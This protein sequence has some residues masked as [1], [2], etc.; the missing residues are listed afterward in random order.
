MYTGII[1]H[2]ATVQAIKPQSSENL[3]LTFR[4][5]SQVRKRL[6]TDDS[7]SIDGACLTVIALSVH[8]FSVEAVPET[9]R[10]TTLGSLRQGE[11][12]NLELSLRAGDAF[13]G[14]F[15]M[16]HVDGVGTVEKLRKEGGSL[17]V[18]IKTPPEMMPFIALKGAIAVNG[19]S[20]TVTEVANNSFGVVLIPH[21][22]SKTNLG[23]IEKGSKVNIEVDLIARMVITFLKQKRGER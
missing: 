12:V 10:L 21:T 20:L 6:H 23:T 8:S 5:S 16:G 11:H 9:L 14:H 3:L 15:V 17:R 2:Q 18:T 13:G 7:V 19:V 4:V 22:L 1:H